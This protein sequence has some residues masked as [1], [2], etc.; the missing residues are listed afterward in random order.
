MNLG[1]FA[2]FWH[3]FRVISAEVCQ[4][5]PTF[6]GHRGA[7]T[8]PDERQH[9]F[10]VT[11]LPTPSQ[12]PNPRPWAPTTPPHRQA[13]WIHPQ[14]LRIFYQGRK[15]HD[16]RRRDR[17]WHDFLHWTFRYFLQ[18][19]G[20]LVL[21][22]CTYILETK[23]KIQWRASN[24]DGAPKLQISV[25]CRGRTCPDFK[26]KKMPWKLFYFLRFSLFF[27]VVFYLRK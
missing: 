13:S 3:N 20:G 11:W 21:I 14:A 2:W 12:S 24:G 6:L 16:S 1:C 27:E 17:I 15:N 23:Q 26:A 4:S 25:P 8:Q 18:I 9:P 22:N 7:P 10:C 5:V 19:L